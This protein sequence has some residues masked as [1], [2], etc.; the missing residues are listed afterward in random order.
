MELIFGGEKPIHASVESITHGV[1]SLTEDSDSFL[2]LE[3]LPMHYMQA[4]K[5]GADS[6]VVEYQQGSLQEHYQACNLSV[7][8]ACE[9]L[10]M[11]F[12]GDESW[13]QACD[14]QSYQW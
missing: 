11:Y 9:L 2:V 7:D 12:H 14:W 8:Q 6:Y 3:R 10:L 1:F 13:R 5:T 4:A